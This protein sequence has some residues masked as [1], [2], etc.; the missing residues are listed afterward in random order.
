MI[1]EFLFDFSSPYSYLAST[2]IE[3]ICSRYGATVSWQPILLGPIFRETGK[4]PLF[5]RAAEGAWARRDLE[6]W[7]ERL[8]VPLR[9]PPEFP[10]RSLAASR[11]MVL[12][13]QAGIG[14]AYCRRLLAAAWGEGRDIA[15]ERVLR[16]I[17]TELSL[18][19]EEY[20]ASIQ[21]PEVKAWLRSRTEEA[22]RRG[23]FGAPTFF[24]DGEMYYG[25]DRLFMVEEALAGRAAGTG[26]PPSRATTP[27]NEWFGIRCVKSG[28]GTAVYEV[29][30]T[31]SLL[32]KRGVAHGGVVTSLLDTA[33]GSAVVSGIDP[34]EWCATLELSVQ[35]REPVRPGRITGTGRM[36]KRGRS[37]AFAEGE[38]RSAQGAVLAVAHGTWYL[39][40]RRPGR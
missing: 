36:V 23:V 28:G 26:A 35:F 17:A 1:V 14:G 9:H 38:I 13:E 19:P 31:P 30:V 34:E 24:L 5:E 39:W 40:P 20:L 27:F 32:N 2:R 33:L 3:A 29:E 11:G 18:D 21:R 15:D 37:A 25:N 22:L 7:A 10:V 4:L 8:G 6:M 12:A 16:A